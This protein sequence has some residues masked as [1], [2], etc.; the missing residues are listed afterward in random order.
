VQLLAKLVRHPA[1]LLVTLGVLWGSGYTLARFATTHGVSPLGYAF[2]QCLGPAVVL[3]CYQVV[4]RQRLRLT[5]PQVAY[6]LLIGLIG[7]TLPNTNMYV[8]SA[9][10]PAGLLAVVVNTTPVFIFLL[11][12]LAGE[13]RLSAARIAALVLLCLGLGLLVWPSMT[14][15]STFSGHPAWVALS[16]LSPLFFAL[17]AVLIANRPMS[18]PSSMMACGMMWAATL[19][20]LPVMMAHHAFYWPSSSWQSRDTAILGEVVLSSVGYIVFFRLLKMAGSV[21]YSFVSGVVAIM[22]VIWGQVFFAEHFTV[23]NI[24]AMSCIV[25]ATALIVLFSSRR[26]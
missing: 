7:I 26:E 6:L 10:L 8:I 22:G 11:A 19:W 17:T 16:L 12:L 9:H 24:I 13:E 3:S 4:S 25:V 15:S 1:F 21:Y 2:W 14:L 23:S 18:L 20:L 5:V